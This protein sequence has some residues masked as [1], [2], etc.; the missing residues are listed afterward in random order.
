MVDAES[1]LLLTSDQSA[2]RGQL[3]LRLLYNQPLSAYLIE[4]VEMAPASFP[5]ATVRLLRSVNKY[6][7]EV[8]RAARIRNLTHHLARAC[9][10]FA[11]FMERELL[12]GW[13]QQF[14]SSPDFWHMRGRTL[15]ENFCLFLYPKL[16][17]PLLSEALRLDGIISG[18]SADPYVASPWTGAMHQTVV[19]GAIATEL[20]QSKVRLLG[21]DGA[22]PCRENLAYVSTPEPA[23]IAVVLS[24]DRKVIVMTIGGES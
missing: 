7:L 1:L 13:V 4:Q 11:A 19:D 24:A 18:L 2:D 22:L 12:H 17:D 10:R 21:D 5:A 8:E 6:H 9:P 14:A 16:P 15:A 3:Y 20:M 23:I